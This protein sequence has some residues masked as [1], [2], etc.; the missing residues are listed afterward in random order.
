MG[1][2]GWNV[3]KLIYPWTIYTSHFS[4][5]IEIIVEVHSLNLRRWLK[6]GLL[7]EICSSLSLEYLL[8]LQAIGRTSARFARKR[9]RGW[10]CSKDISSSSIKVSSHF[11]YFFSY[12]WDWSLKSFLL[13]ARLILG[14]KPFKCEICEKSY[15]RLTSLQFHIQVIH[16]SK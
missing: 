12:P 1:G 9:L 8:V 3:M 11:S 10:K 16:G 2:N 5:E 7:G 6:A 14:D 15:P 13:F 4:V